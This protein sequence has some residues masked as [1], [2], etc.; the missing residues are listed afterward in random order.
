VQHREAKTSQFTGV[1]WHKHVSKWWAKCKGTNLGYHTKEEAAANAYNVEAER[2]GLPLNVI[3]PARATS[4]GGG[5]GADPGPKRVGAGASLKRAGAGAGP[6]RAV[7]K[8][9]A[10]PAPS[11]KMKL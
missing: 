7:P 2:L 11:K 10:K 5:A 3:P 1:C 6:K 9:S 8:T 4:A